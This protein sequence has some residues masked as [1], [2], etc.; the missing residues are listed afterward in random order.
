[1]NTDEAEI[2]AI[3]DLFTVEER[4]KVN[5][6]MSEFWHMAHASTNPKMELILQNRLER[7]CDERVKM[8]QELDR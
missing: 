1:M 8:L 6:D 5:A 2:I 7:I 3:Y 4:L